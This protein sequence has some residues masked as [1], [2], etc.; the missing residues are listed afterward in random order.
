MGVEEE[1]VIVG[2]GVADHTRRN[3]WALFVAPGYER[4]EMGRSLLKVM[5]EWLFEMAFEANLVNYRARNTLQNDSTVSAG[6]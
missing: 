1:G 6:W 2:F 4:R 5:V 3:I